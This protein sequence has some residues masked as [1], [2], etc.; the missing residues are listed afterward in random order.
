MYQLPG[1]TYKA[2][3]AGTFVSPSCAFP[4][5]T[6]SAVATFS[7]DIQ[8]LTPGATLAPNFVYTVGRP[9]AGGGGQRLFGPDGRIHYSDSILGPGGEYQFEQQVQCFTETL[10]AGSLGNSPCS[11]TASVL[12][13][14]QNSTACLDGLTKGLL[15]PLTPILSGHEN[16]LQ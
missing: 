3:Y 8:G 6:A 1:N 7:N 13:C 9:K 2:S 5:N 4:V 16:I 15:S 14:M 12:A 10:G 11:G